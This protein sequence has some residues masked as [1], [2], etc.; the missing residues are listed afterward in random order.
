MK[1]ILLTGFA[2]LLVAAFDSQTASRALTRAPT[3]IREKVRPLIEVSGSQIKIN[4]TK[5]WLGDTMDTWKRALGGAPTCY[6]AGLIVTC[7]W[8]STGLLLGT[9]HLDK[10]RVTFMKLHI[11]IEPAELG[12]RSPSW[13]KSPFHG[14]LEL[15]GIPIHPDTA[16]RDLRRQ[17]PHSRELRCGDGGCGNPSAAFSD[18]ANIHMNLARRSENAPILSFSISCSRTELC[19]SLIP[20]HVINDRSVAVPPL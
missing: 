1:N 3:S 11:T 15:D 10:T 18:G 13:P 5:V 20:N 12:E 17:V 6:D 16:F 14:T 4:G 8:H 9:D 7:V 19:T 2:L